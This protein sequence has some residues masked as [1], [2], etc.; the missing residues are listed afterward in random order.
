MRVD[1]V[2][3]VD[4]KIFNNLLATFAKEDVKED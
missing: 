3:L 2:R 4:I 1:H